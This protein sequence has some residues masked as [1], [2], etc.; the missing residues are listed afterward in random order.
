MQTNVGITEKAHSI[1]PYRV[2]SKGD[3]SNYYVDASKACSSADDKVHSMMLTE[4]DNRTAIGCYVTTP[5]RNMLINR[6]ADYVI[7]CI[8]DLS[9][10]TL[11][12]YCCA[13]HWVVIFEIYNISWCKKNI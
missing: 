8:L 12:P 11:M 6:T 7:K 5:T 2:I 1:E 9:G 13:I 4:L 3:G 10:G